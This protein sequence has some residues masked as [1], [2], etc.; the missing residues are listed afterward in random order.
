MCCL[1]LSPLVV[2]SQQLA[3]F[4]PNLLFRKRMFGHATLPEEDVMFGH[5]VKILTTNIH[6][7]NNQHNGNGLASSLYYYDYARQVITYYSSYYRSLIMRI[8]A[9]ATPFFILGVFSTSY[10]HVTDASAGCEYTYGATLETW[11]GIDGFYISDLMTATNNLITPPDSSVRLESILEAP[12]NIGDNY[13]QRIKGWLVA[14]ENGHYTFWIASDDE[15]QLYLSPDDDPANKVLIA[16]VVPPD[17]TYSREWDKLSTQQ[18][19]QISLT[20]G[21]AYYMEALMKEKW[22]GDN[23]AL[24]WSYGSQVQQVI[25]ADH[26]RICEPSSQPSSQPSLSPSKSVHPSSEPSLNPS[27]STNPTSEPSSEPSSQPSSQ[28]SLSPSGSVQPSSEPSLNPSFS[29]NPTSEPSS[30][31]PLSRHL[32]QVCL[33]LSQFIRRLSHR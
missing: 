19:A 25:P 17:W 6:N 7:T 20:A 28:P 10:T 2:P 12:T 13:G 26:M 5:A 27:F 30:E 15:G 11:T 24:A 9:T 1:Y 3:L 32:N 29:T 22:G 14:P 4:L 16:N 33:L 23:L 8:Y 18:S 31:P 21:S